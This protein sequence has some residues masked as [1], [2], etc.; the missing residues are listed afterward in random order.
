VDVAVLLEL[1]EVIAGFV[2][3]LADGVVA[4]RIVDGIHVL[5]ELEVGFEVLSAD[6]A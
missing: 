3:D 6:D 5:A 4:V 2:A 1:L